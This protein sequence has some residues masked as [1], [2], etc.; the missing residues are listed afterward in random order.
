MTFVDGLIYL[1][2]CTVNEEKPDP[3][4]IRGI[5]IENLFQ[6]ARFH[7]MTALIAP[8]LA[9]AGIRDERFSQELAVTIW[10]E[11]VMENQL[12][13]IEAAFD[14]A[15]IWH[16]SLKGAVLKKYYPEPYLRMM[17]DVDLLVD[18]DGEEKTDEIMSALGF[19]KKK[20]PNHNLEYHGMYVKKPL[21][22]FEIHWKLFG[23]K[24]LYRSGYEYYQDIE[25]R[26][27]KDDGQPLRRH[28]SDEDFYLYMIA[29][30]YRHYNFGGTGLRSLLDTYVYLKK[31]MD[32]MDWKY[33]RE[34]AGKMDLTSF[35]E[36][37]R[38]LA[39]KVFAPDGLKT[40][41]GEQEEMLDYFV[42][43]GTYGI[44]AHVSANWLKNWGRKKY[45]I[46]RIFLPLRTV[47]K[48]YPFFDRHKIL[49]PVLPL[50]RI[51]THRK[52]FVN[53]VRLF[54]GRRKGTP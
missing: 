9:Q 3:D 2:A 34:E 33:I 21:S 27:I 49:L 38:K 51:F 54:L 1:A 12:K 23:E 42:S 20:D 32:S 47:K 5:D 22:C 37:N 7:Q 8:A 43:S 31:F 14:E 40:L 48:Q 11:M 4:L 17:S 19:V 13:Q 46:H 50:Y 45:L 18:P 15:G 35:E 26:L 28:F 16:M 10:K 36:K 29:H 41:T 30:E 39:M 44:V 6:F 53:E 24:T 52:R 25:K